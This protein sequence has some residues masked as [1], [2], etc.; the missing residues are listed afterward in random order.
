MSVT[1]SSGTKPRPFEPNLTA[2][3]YSLKT[4]TTSQ[5]LDMVRTALD[6]SEVTYE[7]VRFDLFFRTE[8]KIWDGLAGLCFGAATGL[9][10]SDMYGSPRVPVSPDILGQSEPTFSSTVMGFPEA[11]TWFVKLAEDYPPEAAT[12]W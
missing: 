9:K 10:H 5:T 1:R 2:A 3:G 6:L 8:Q 7:P 11:V 12:S 4:R